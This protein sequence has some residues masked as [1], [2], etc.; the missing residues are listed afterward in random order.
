MAFSNWLWHWENAFPLCVQYPDKIVYDIDSYYMLKKHYDQ[1]GVLGVILG[2]DT[3][4]VAL[5]VSSPLGM[6]ILGKLSGNFTFTSY[7]WNVPPHYYILYNSSRLKNLNVNIPNAFKV[8]YN[9]EV[10]LLP[11]HQHHTTLI[12]DSVF[13]SPEWLENINDY[14]QA[15]HEDICTAET[16]DWII[17]N[18]ISSPKENV[19]VENIYKYYLVDMFLNKAVHFD[20][21][22]CF[23]EALEFLNHKVN[24]GIISA[25]IFR[26]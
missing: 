1:E 15:E 11:N 3:G 19:V 18:V 8:M 10:V 2:R 7:S 12:F 23:I 4:Y 5:E 9:N 16:F 25:T 20:T 22:K 26:R 21:Y 13:E 17:N 24:D 6:A 14:Y